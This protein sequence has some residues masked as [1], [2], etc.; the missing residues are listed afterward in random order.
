MR[1][2]QLP[3]KQQLT[4]REMGGVSKNRKKTITSNPQLSPSTYFLRV[5]V[6]S[7]LN[8]QI[9]RTDIPTSAHSIP[10]PHNAT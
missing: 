10:L 2:S 4:Q 1:N 6:H 8:L 7:L 3:D 5:H 9:I